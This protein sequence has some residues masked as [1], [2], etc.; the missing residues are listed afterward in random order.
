MSHRC[1]SKTKRS[2]S[3]IQQTLKR[4]LPRSNSR[5][6]KS[7]HHS[8]RTV[9]MNKSHS[10]FA[11]SGERFLRDIRNDSSMSV[12]EWQVPQESSA[13]QKLRVILKWELQH[14][15]S[16]HPITIFG[17]QFTW[18]SIM[19]KFDDSPWVTSGSGRYND[20]ESPQDLFFFSFLLPN[21]NNTRYFD[22]AHDNP[23][24]SLGEDD[25]MPTRP[26]SS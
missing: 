24:V 17:P 10:W 26:P 1:L 13:I 5:R 25:M 15:K 20:L 19:I 4:E 7:S 16:C 23:H 12:H 6:I 11:P 9:L 3:S 18:L 22:L 14:S 21:L 2:Q 8:M